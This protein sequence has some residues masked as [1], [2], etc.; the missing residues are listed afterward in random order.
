MCNFDPG[1]GDDLIVTITDPVIFTRW[2]LGL[3][4]WAQALRS[5]IQ[6]SAPTDLQRGFRRGTLHL[7]W[8][9]VGGSL[10]PF[11]Q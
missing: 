3:I 8:P 10:T 1:F 11:R 7:S 5:G 9:G 4:S 2:Q 6:V